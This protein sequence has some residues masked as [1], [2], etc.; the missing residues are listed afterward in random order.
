MPGPIT[1]VLPRRPAICARVSAGL[2]TVA[3]R[4]PVHPV[5]REFLRAVE[6]PV[7]APSA[8]S[9]TRPSP[10]CALHV[11]H[12]LGDKVPLILDGGNCDGGIESTVVDATG[13]RP[14]IL[15]PGLITREMIGR[16]AAVDDQKGSDRVVR[17]PGVKYRHYAPRC[18]VKLFRHGDVSLM[19]KR[20]DESAG[21]PV[22][23]CCRETADRLSGNTVVLGDN[24]REIARN[25]YGALLEAEEAFD[26]ILLEACPE[27]DLGTSINNRMFKTGG[28]RW[29]EDEP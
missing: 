11:F 8:N 16:I 22:F 24:E 25:F 2:D 9:S 20:Y 15:R 4:V 28:S 18:P 23:L 12:D 13:D 10:T 27:D 29:E 17:S 19:Q 7:A 3:V 26:L 6:V 1:L 5:A 14:K 21:H